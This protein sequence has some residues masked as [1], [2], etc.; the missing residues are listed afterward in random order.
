MGCGCLKRAAKRRCSTARTSTGGACTARS[1]GTSKTVNSS[2]LVKPDSSEQGLLR[3][4]TWNTLR[5]RA[6]G[7]RV[8][9]WLNGT[10]IVD[11]RDEKIGAATGVI[12][13]QIHDG[14]G[15]KVRWR[16]LYVTRLEKSAGQ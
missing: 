9:T 6:V 14:G 5:V 8:T 2:W 4:G 13:L 1:G 10:E 7:D 12:A 3:V 11:M 16:N 15:I